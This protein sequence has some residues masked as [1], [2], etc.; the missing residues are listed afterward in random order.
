[1]PAV[2]W[3][4][5]ETGQP[6]RRYE[7]KGRV[8]QNPA[9]ITIARELDRALDGALDEAV[10]LES[11]VHDEHAGK[12]FTAAWAIGSVLRGSRLSEH[13]ALKEE[14]DALLWDIMAEKAWISVRS[15]G[16]IE[17]AWESIRPVKRGRKVQRHGSEK[18]DD[19]WSMCR[20]LAEQSYGDA[21]L[22]FG[23]NVRNVWQMLDRTTLRPLVVRK[24]LCGWLSD[25]SE[26]GR[27]R[28]THGKAFPELMKALRKRWPAKGSRSALQPIHL[29]EDELRSE[30]AKVALEAGLLDAK[31][32]LA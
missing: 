2:R 8:T 16:T 30:I 13:R 23:G 1:M 31:R 27:G 3:I 15:D 6:Q 24:A 22:T 26:E 9:E 18:G 11:R 7:A 4:R 10:D 17:V 19:Y 12:K 25:L 28:L 32:D 20:W 21:V 14:D 29:G 5:E